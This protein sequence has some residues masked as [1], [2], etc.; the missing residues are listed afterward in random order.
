[1]N[2]QAAKK[3]VSLLDLPRNKVYVKINPL[4]N[5]LVLEKIKG[6]FVSVQSFIK[7]N[8]LNF[9][10]Y[11]W[12]KKGEYPL[13]VLIKIFKILKLDG[14]SIEKNL[15]YIRSGIY[16]PRGKLGGNLSVPVNVKFPL[17]LTKELTRV[18]SHLFADGCLSIDKKGYLTAQYYNHSKVLLKQFK[19]D[20]EKVFN[21]YDLKKKFNKKVPYFYLPSP[22]ALIL[23]EIIPTFHSKHCSVPLFIL[24][25]PL[26]MKK[27]FVGAFFDDEAHVKFKPPYRNIELKTNN[28]HLMQE[29]KE[30]LLEF[31]IKTTPLLK[32]RLRGF[33]YFCFYVRSYENLKNF[34]E[35]IGFSEIKKAETLKKILLHPGRKSY[36]RG[37]TDE[38][39]LSLLKERSLTINE[40]STMLNRDYSTIHLR[41]K[42]LFSNKRII[43]ENI[44]GL[45]HWRVYEK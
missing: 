29:I 32:G 5:K 11:R 34:K 37:E 28:E 15:N 25:S 45:N 22:L 16:P 21:F 12:L 27:A 1:M 44:K 20:I 14:K 24:D 42:H 26:E 23:L 31:D 9:S 39:I 8:S 38:K 7:K 17:N 2:P 18:I 30:L 10:I 3:L 40:L 33:E 43:K 41:I 4:L 13:S 35:R 6:K 19:E 36:A